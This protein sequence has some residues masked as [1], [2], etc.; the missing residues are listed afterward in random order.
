MAQSARSP[1]C[2]GPLC[3]QGSGPL[4]ALCD[5][6]PLSPGVLRSPL[7]PGVPSPLCPQV[8]AVPR[9]TGPRCPQV[10]A[11][12]WGVQVP[13]VS[14]LS[15]GPRCPQPSAPLPPVPQEMCLGQ[16]GLQSRAV[17]SSSGPARSRE[18]LSPGEALPGPAT[19]PAVGP[20]WGQARSGHRSGCPAR[21]GTGQVQLSSQAGD[22]PERLQWPEEL[23]HP[24]GPSSR[25]SF[26]FFPYFALFI[27]NY[28]PCAAAAAHLPPCA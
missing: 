7:C 6:A 10:P 15:P 25:L 27:F 5:R 16:E 24:V 1:L 11:V 21:L 12:P 20:G 18:G 4:C 9:V 3:L 23:C 2:P 22:R 28:S 19:G 17:F 14:P 26:A 8:P 13:S